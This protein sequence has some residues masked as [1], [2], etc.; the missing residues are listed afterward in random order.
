MKQQMS[1]EMVL[2]TC[3]SCGMPFAISSQLQ[4]ELRE[5]HNTFYCPH[6]HHNYFPAKTDQEK[7]REKLTEKSSALAAAEAQVKTLQ[8]SL[9]KKTPKRAKKAVKA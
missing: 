7:L 2:M 8:E 3:A 5:C 4:G 6:G 9:A 1:I